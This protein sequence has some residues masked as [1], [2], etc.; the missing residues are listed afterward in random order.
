V[1]GHNDLPWAI[2]LANGGPGNVR[3]YD[4]RARTA[5][6]TDLPRLREG[7]VGGQFWSVYIPCELSGRQARRVQLEQIRVAKEVIDAYPEALA[8][9]HSA[10]D[11]RRCFAQGR[12]A[13]LIAIEGGQAIGRSLSEL[14]G[15]FDLGVRCMTFT[16]NCTHAWADAALGEPRHGGLTTFGVEVVRE[17]NRIGM[18]VDLSHASDATMRA[19]MKVARAPLFW[20]H[21][22][23]RAL[24]DHPRNVPD[25]VLEWVGAHGGIVM[26]TFVPAFVNPAHGEWKARETAVRADAAQGRGSDDALVAEA[27]KMWQ[28]ENP[29]PRAKLAHVADHV[30]HIR[31]VAGVDHV[32]IGGDFDGI[33]QVVEGLEDVS[34]YPALFAELSRRGWSDEELGKL[35]GENVLRVMEAAEEAARR[36]QKDARAS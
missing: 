6:H 30:E 35:A 28:R 2:R 25:E 4:L 24:V 32:G 13:S 27:V 23:A 5:G 36:L 1:D 34:T 3:S 8:V 17:M 15:Y 11:V 10:A 33:S 7:M 20:T 26:A 16:H 21:A 19:A 12:I 18:L 22:G 9:A 31:R 14:R 29:P